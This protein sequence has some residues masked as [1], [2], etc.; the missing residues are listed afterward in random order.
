VGTVAVSAQ[1]QPMMLEYV[2]ILMIG[3]RRLNV[4]VE[5][6]KRLS[7]TGWRM[8]EIVIAGV[9]LLEILVGPPPPSGECGLGIDAQNASPAIGSALCPDLYNLKLIFASTAQ[10]ILSFTNWVLDP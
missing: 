1:N 6:G 5:I 9:R 10:Y 8:M 4:P 7:Q 2:V 3:E